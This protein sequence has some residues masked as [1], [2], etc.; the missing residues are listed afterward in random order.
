M[1]ILALV[2]EPFFVVKGSSIRLEHTFSALAEAGHKVDVLCYPGGANL[3]IDGVRI[4]R[5]PF[6]PGL[7]SF[8]RHRGWGNPFMNLLMF[9]RAGWLCLRGGYEAVHVVQPACWF[10]LWYKRPLG[11]FLI[12]DLHGPIR[13]TLRDTA[14]ILSRPLLPWKEAKSRRTIENADAVI[15]RSSGLAEKLKE[16]I[17]EGKFFF[18]GD[19]P[20]AASFQPDE[21]GAGQLRSKHG[22]GQNPVV[23]YTGS[24]DAAHGVDVLL[25]AAQRIAKSVD[26]VKVIFVGGESDQIA[27]MEKLARSLDLAETC[28]FVGEQPMSRIPAYISAATVL[29]SPHLRSSYPVSKLFTYMQSGKPIVATR[30]PAHLDVLDESCSILVVPQAEA[31][32]DG[33]LRALRE[34]LL[35]QGLG[36]E[37]MA[38][39]GAKYSL[40]S[41]RHRVR[42][43][44]QQFE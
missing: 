22:I 2:P 34:P 16:E 31:I 11:R 13:D 10:S 17:P 7:A 23:V 25:R 30:I 9:L 40:S 1:K 18:I 21:E 20:L 6:L 35:A 37:A 3:D 33:V 26:G 8:A 4:R 39:V 32:A 27:R 14:S 15:V 12:C 5:V 29:V 24:F 44:Y 42:S 38:R 19:A 36:I 28:L 43:V 41:F